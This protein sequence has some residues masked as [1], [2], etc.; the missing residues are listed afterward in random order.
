MKCPYCQEEME[1]G[2]I[3]SP[4]EISWKKEKH[5]LAR[6]KFYPGS[7]VL[8]KLSLLSGSAVDAYCCRSCR[9]VIINY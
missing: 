6:A 7:I 4:Q 5:L 1:L 8:A 2:V 9:K 3:Q